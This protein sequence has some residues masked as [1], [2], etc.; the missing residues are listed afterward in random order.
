MCVEDTQRIYLSA[1]EIDESKKLHYIE[2]ESSKSGM[3]DQKLNSFFSSH[4]D[5]RSTCSISIGYLQEER[6]SVK[7]FFRFL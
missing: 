2:D 5:L 4:L 6:L 7:I 1:K 3:Q